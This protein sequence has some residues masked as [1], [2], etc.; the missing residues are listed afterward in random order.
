ML[1]ILFNAS[2]ES[3]HCFNVWDINSKLKRFIIDSA[4]DCFNF[5]FT[6]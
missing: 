2:D 5:C 4:I 6:F 3:I 1:I